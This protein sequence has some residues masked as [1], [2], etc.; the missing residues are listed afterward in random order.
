MTTTIDRNEAFATE[1]RGQMAGARQRVAKRQQRIADY[2][3][4]LLQAQL[5]AKLEKDI[6]SGYIKMISPDKYRVMQGFD[7]GEIFTV[8]KATRPGELPLILPESGLEVVDGTASLFTAKP[9][10]HELGF[11]NG[12]EAT[13]DV[14]LAITK[15]G[16][17]F[18]IDHREVFFYDDHG[19]I[20]P[21]P[22]KFATART[23]TWD[24]LGVVGKI[25]KSVSPRESLGWLQS[26]TGKGELL[27]ES[28][29]VLRGGAKTFI[30]V[31]LPDDIRIDPQGVNVEVRPYLAL[32][33]DHAGERK[34]WA[35]ITPW[36]VIC[37][38]THNFAL[39]DAVTRWGVRHS[40][41]IHGK[42]DIA[43]E[44]LGLTIKGYEAFTA[45]EEAL[46]RTPMSTAEFEKFMA[47]LWEPETAESTKN[48]RTRE[49]KRND[50]LF[51]LLA[52]ETGRLGKNW[53]AGE[54]ALTG[55]W[56]NVVRDATEGKAAVTRATA[57]LE[58]EQKNKLAVHRQLLVA[59]GR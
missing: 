36:V 7:Q 16:L 22:G 9:A 21:V 55:Y 56:D 40:T 24:G 49:A 29:G 48:A 25:H 23:D 47:E 58:G 41:N 32:L 33:D 53:F 4:G 52:Q 54:M 6:A 51:G 30:T 15:G 38:N 26:L 18:D 57:L 19:G 44:T 20:H 42:L 46:L 10:W 2:D 11:D 28:A 43:R 27:I 45:E 39:R 35:I 14:D 1:K 8:R 5:D 50:A 59:A 31:R 12:G 37:G 17:D 3:S 34:L 13:T